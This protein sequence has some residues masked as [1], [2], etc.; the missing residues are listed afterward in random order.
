M[1]QDYIHFQ[2]AISYGF[3]DKVF[4]KVE[5]LEEF[6]NKFPT[7]IYRDDAL[8]ELGNTYVSQENYKDALSAYN[9]LIRSLPNSSYVSKSLLK[10]ALILENT[11]KS[12]EAITLFK[13]VANDFPSSQEAIQAVSSAKIIYIEQGRVNEYATWVR[14]L[15]FVN[16]EHSEN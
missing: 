14:R 5:G 9:T 12:N 15:D 4:L 13:R 16:L 1:N 2:K 7:S 10:K 11:G 3:V 6:F 8:Y